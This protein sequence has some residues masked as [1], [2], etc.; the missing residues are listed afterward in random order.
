MTY[1]ASA[2]KWY[3]ISVPPRVPNGRPGQAPLLR[4]VVGHAEPIDADELR[5]RADGEPADLV[6]RR[7]IALEQR[8]RQLQH[9]GDVVEAVARLVGRQQLGDLDVEVRAGR[10]PR[11]DTRRG[12]NDGTARCGPGSGWRRPSASSSFSS[13]PTSASR[14]SVA[15]RGSPTGGIMPARSLR[16]TSSHSAGCAATSLE[17]QRLQA[18]VGRPL[19]V[20]VAARA[21]AG[22][23]GLVLADERPRATAR[24]RRARRRR[25]PG[26]RQ[27][28]PSRS[29]VDYSQVTRP[30][31]G[32]AMPISRGNRT[33]LALAVGGLTAA[34]VAQ[35]NAAVPISA[36]AS[37]ARRDDGG[38]LCRQELEGAAH[39][40]G[41]PELRGRV[42]HRRLARSADGAAARPS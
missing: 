38:G 33:I 19:D 34:A 9:A 41:P 7:E 37:H 22:D 26:V 15:G 24:S 11:C 31:R 28:W 16:I 4:A 18:Q 39:V 25:R 29:S 2:G 14:A 17:R 5:R 1:S 27:C 12:S 6:G 10:G 21:I 30:E 32:C 23:G 36:T 42:E 40:V 20:V 35:D 8:R 13:Q 3:S